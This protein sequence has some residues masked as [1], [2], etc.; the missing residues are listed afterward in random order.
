MPVVI[1]FLLD[2]STQNA[3][4]SQEVPA[5]SGGADAHPPPGVVRVIDRDR[6]RT[7]SRSS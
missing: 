5:G 1:K 6:T 7:V 4:L 3:W 2:D